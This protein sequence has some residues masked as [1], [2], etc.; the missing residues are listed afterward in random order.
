MKILAILIGLMVAIGAFPLIAQTVEG[1]GEY[2]ANWLVTSQYE[3]GH[4]WDYQYFFTNDTSAGS[5]GTF[6]RSLIVEVEVPRSLA[7]DGYSA[8]VLTRL[9]IEATENDAPILSANVT[10]DAFGDMSAS[11][12]GTH[13]VGWF[14]QVMSVACVLGWYN[15]TLTLMTLS[16]FELGGPGRSHLERGT[17]T[18]TGRRGELRHPPGD[19]VLA[20]ECGTFP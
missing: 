7:G 3:D 5:F 9:H 8:A 16:G 10:M 15:F 19:K 13:W 11:G 14:G 18:G 20:R 6:I 2:N 4:A 1:T 17:G 12:D